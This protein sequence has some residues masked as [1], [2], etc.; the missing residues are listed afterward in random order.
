MK[1]NLVILFVSFSI[2]GC[3]S[4]KYNREVFTVTEENGRLANESYV[5][6]MNFVKGWM[7]YRDSLSG[8]IPTN[9]SGKK[10]LWEPFNSAAD[11]Y[12]FM[13]LTSYLLDQDLYNG[14]MLDMLRSEQ[15]LTSRIGS[16][17]DVFRFS[18]QNFQTEMPDTNWVIFGTSEYIKDGLIPLTEYIGSSPWT[19]RM[20][21]MLEDLSGYYT[22]FKNMDK[23]GSYKAV[24]EEVNGS[25]LQTLSRIY[26]LTGNKK[27]L[28]WAIKIGDYYLVE[29]R[30][31]SSVE[32]LRLRDHGCEIIGGLSE[33]YVT[34][35]YVNPEKKNQY[36]ER[37][38]KV[39]DRVLEV[40]RNRD[41]L[42]YNAI[43]TFT[44]ELADSGIVDNW[45][46]IFDAY[47]SVY[48]V[49]K[50]EEYRQAFLDVIENLNENYRN[51]PWE[52]K[53][54]DGYADAIESGINLYNREKVPELKSWIDSEIKVMWGMQQSNG[55]VGGAHPDG[56]FA[57]TA[58]MYAL[59][60]TMGVHC[61]PWREDLKFGSEVRDGKLFIS[62][63]SDKAWKGI[64]TFDYERHKE[65]LHL[66]VDYPRINQFPEWF[67]V[68]DQK[69]YKLTDYNKKAKTQVTG[70]ELRKGI[71]MSLSGGEGYHIVVEEVNGTY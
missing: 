2:I 37:F 12:V 61:S 43:N 8:L 34:L 38:Y 36:R 6:S 63:S 4:F 67:T 56:N 44:G 5:R 65:I 40:G 46:Y 22:V 53:S 39:L 27:Y 51:Y 28:D 64:L 45:G 71:E 11:N 16:L 7:L 33:L 18:T 3:N 26:W 50:K 24:S 10:D 58:I 66:P 60:K 29:N 35:N 19:E 1:F 21:E 62:V 20:M 25:M 68:K 42:F 9:L 54:H 30:D 31:L 14:P 41:G 15:Q 69:D 48:L 13:V 47:Y 32:Y 52:G 57:R 49:D 59:W 55:I 70:E 17:P 23:L